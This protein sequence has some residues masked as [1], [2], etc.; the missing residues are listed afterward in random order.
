MT[1]KEDVTDKKTIFV[2]A[3]SS[4]SSRFKVFWLEVQS[5]DNLSDRMSVRVFR[6]LSGTKV[7]TLRR[8]AV[9]E[10]AVKILL[11]CRIY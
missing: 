3:S 4:V 11:G 5:S 10:D 7:Q 9:K 6:F 2:A 8:S 1:L